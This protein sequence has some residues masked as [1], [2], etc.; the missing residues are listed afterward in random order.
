MKKTIIAVLLLIIYYSASFSQDKVELYD[1]EFNPQFRSVQLDGSFGIWSKKIGGA[2]DY[3][4]FSNRNKKQSWLS[5][6][7]RTGADVIWLS[8]MSGD[9]S[10]VTH[11]NLYARSSIEGEI[12]RLDAYGGSAYQFISKEST[13][14]KNELVFKGG[15]D[16]K[17]K[18][19]PYTG[20]LLNFGLST[21]ESY[22]GLGIYLA[23]K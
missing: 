22:F 3:D 21:G 9:Y 18:L 10:P 1:F 5:V 13:K 8:E 19:S 12:I 6:G 23:F 14:A 2:I 16:F 7:L 17:V 20:L 15:L 4:L 11:I